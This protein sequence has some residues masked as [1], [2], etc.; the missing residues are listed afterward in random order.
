MKCGKAPQGIWQ[1]SSFSGNGPGND[2]LELATAGYMRKLREGDDP[3][4][5]ITTTLETLAGLIRGIKNGAFD[6]QLE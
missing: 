3:D 4:A 2:C 1:K 6:G 5:V